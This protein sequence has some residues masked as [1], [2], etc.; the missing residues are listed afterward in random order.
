VLQG[1]YLSWVDPVSSHWW[2]ETWFGG[3]QPKFRD[4]GPLSAQ[5]TSLR[6]QIDRITTEERAKVTGEGRVAATA[7]GLTV[8]VTQRSTT[9]KA[10]IWR[11][12]INAILEQANR[13]TPE[14]QA[15]RRSA[16]R[17]R[18]GD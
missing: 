8:E 15:E 9:S 12:Q 5:G 11:D 6:A 2:Q 1:G 10:R 14:G 13:S 17:I 3:G 4:I 7:A 18:K 16:P